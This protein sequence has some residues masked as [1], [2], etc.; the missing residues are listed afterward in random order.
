MK[1]SL[2][3]INTLGTPVFAPFI[4]AR[5]KKMAEIINE[6]EIDI[7]CLQEI[8]TYYHLYLFKKYLKNFPYVMYQSF[9][10][11]PK[12]GLVIFSK[13]PMEQMTYKEFSA[14]GEF[15]N[16]SFYSR[17]LRNGILSARLKG[18]PVT[19]ATTHLTC[20]Y[21]FDWAPENHLF[22]HVER[23]MKDVI[24]K[25]KDITKD[26]TSLILTGDF[27]TK[28]HGKLYDTL[29][30]ET[31]LTDAF[32]DLESP[33]YDPSRVYYKFM[34]KHAARIDHLFFYKGKAHIKI[35]K[36]NEIFNKKVPLSENKLSYLSDHI[37][38]KIDFDIV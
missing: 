10:Y 32:D 1:L 13:H 11:G 6:Q 12:G 2:I 23:Q 28:K 35:I 25:V 33:T 16:I 14:L 15:K 17:I 34:A 24:Q 26:N 37:G 8:Q 27:N 20:D 9:F 4:T 5:Y 19:I 21:F 30:K 29:L 31:G 3:T 36:H 18:T 22:K 38:L 7:V